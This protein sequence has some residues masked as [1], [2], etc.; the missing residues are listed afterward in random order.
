MAAREEVSGRAEDLAK[1]GSSGFRSLSE[2][3]L[4]GSVLIGKCVC[5]ESWVPLKSWS[6]G[7]E[8][9]GDPAGGLGLV[10]TWWRY[11]LVPL[12][13][14]VVFGISVGMTS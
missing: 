7:S 6:R 5:R 1:T 11:L 4:A 8:G 3:S 2:R 14:A 10:V 13:E 9:I 12:G